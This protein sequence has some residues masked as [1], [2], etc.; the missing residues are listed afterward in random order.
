MKMM[1]RG[2]LPSLS[3][4]RRLDKAWV[5][6]WS[7]HGRDDC[8]SGRSW[9]GGQISPCGLHSNDQSVRDG[10]TFGGCGFPSS[11]FTEKKKVLGR[12]PN[13]FVQH[14]TQQ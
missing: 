6:G 13:T 12:K 9:S 10:Q 2:C 3:G 5:D 4:R 7:R 8:E 11:K 14:Y 1:M